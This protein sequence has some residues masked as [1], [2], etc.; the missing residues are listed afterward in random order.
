MPEGVNSSPLISIG[1][2]VFNGQNF[3]NQAIDS[4]QNQSYTNFQLIISDNG[5]Y[6]DTPMICKRY[7]AQDKRI[8]FHRFDENQGA[9]RNYNKTFKL[10][11]GK[12]FRWLAHDDKLHQDNLSKSV[13]I[14]ETDPSFVLC[15][16]SK[17]H[18]DNFGSV[19]NHFNFKELELSSKNVT[20][21]FDSFLNHFKHT[22][23]DAD[24]ILT[25]LIRRD[26]LKDTILI[27]N[28]TSADFTLLADLILKGRFIIL[29]DPLYFKRV[30]HGMSMSV[31]N[32]D[33][34]TAV[35]MNLST[36]INYKSHAE[37]AK[38]YDPKGK[39]RRIPHFT[40]LNELLNSIEKNDFPKYRKAHLRKKVYEWF[41]KRMMKS[42]KEKIKRIYL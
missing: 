8:I 36:K 24:L 10:A 30:H 29:E 39:V 1:L 7:A 34:E 4:V 42:V 23:A 20:Q 6:D 33:P 32:G 3:I 35:K 12:Y 13:E 2:P 16:S 38:W 19:I 26:V 27:A 18:I 31:L 21:R 9:S 17:T 37:V 28:Y 5:S 15:G 11:T 22:F 25:G 14:L 41:L 40:W